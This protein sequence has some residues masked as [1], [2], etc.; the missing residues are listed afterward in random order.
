MARKY[1]ELRN[2]MSSERRRRNDV[3]TAKMLLDLNLQELRQTIA[4]RNQDE[5]AAILNVTQGYISRLER[6]DDML[7]SKLYAFVE[8]LGGQVEIRARFPNREVRITQFEDR[9][10]AALERT[11]RNKQT[12]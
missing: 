1:A 11:E 9:L 4:G 12:A 10:K 8:A 3:E 5:L 6:Q 7:L 2:K